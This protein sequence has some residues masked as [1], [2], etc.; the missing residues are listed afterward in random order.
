VKITP[1]IGNGLKFGIMYFLLS[2]PTVER[3]FDE[4]A[5]NNTK[6]CL[7]VMVGSHESFVW[8]HFRDL[9]NETFK[10]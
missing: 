8:F 4:I 9:E 1:V 5:S 6:M 3:C 10:T 7:E 2:G